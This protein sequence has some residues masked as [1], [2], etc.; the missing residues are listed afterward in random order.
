MSAA[1]HGFA[2]LVWTS[3]KHGMA[4]ASLSYKARY[5]DW[6]NSRRRRQEGK[7]PLGTM[8]LNSHVD[9]DEARPKTVDRGGKH[10]E[11]SRPKNPS[12]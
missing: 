4:L 6:A 7:Y 1:S 11:K 2:W 9:V 10:N 12:K 3:T 8:N 5:L